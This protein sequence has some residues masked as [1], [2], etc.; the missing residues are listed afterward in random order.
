MIIDRFY[1]KPVIRRVNASSMK[2]R[3]RSGGAGAELMDGIGMFEQVL[4]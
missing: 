3:H 4:R 1:Y 2:K